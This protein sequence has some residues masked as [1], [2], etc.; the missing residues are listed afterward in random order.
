MKQINHEI[1]NKNFIAVNKDLIWFIS[2]I[3]IL[4]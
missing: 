2:S 4:I 3:I 1:A